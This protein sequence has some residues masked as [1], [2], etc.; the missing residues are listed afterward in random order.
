MP[1]RRKLSRLQW[2]GGLVSLFLAS[3]AGLGVCVVLALA[4]CHRAPQLTTQEAAGKHLYDVR[5]AHCHEDNDLAL[6]KVP[7]DLHGVFKHEKLPS[8]APA[9]DADV[10]RVV[11]GGKGMMPPFAGRFTQEEMAA[12]LAYLHT[13]LR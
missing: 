13:G 11:L 12:L 8:G 5:C 10:Q 1:D 9:T 7:P 4:G 3:S 6:K 2:A